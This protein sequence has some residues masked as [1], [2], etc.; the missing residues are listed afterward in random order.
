MSQVG[1]EVNMLQGLYFYFI[2]KSIGA[3]GLSFSRSFLC[4]IRLDKALIFCVCVRV[5]LLLTLLP[6]LEVFLFL[7]LA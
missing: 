1:C 3:L 2:L 4:Y 6:F 5:L 7:F